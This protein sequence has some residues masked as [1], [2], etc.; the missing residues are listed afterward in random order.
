MVER[1]FLE[2]LVKKL[3]LAREIGSHNG[4]S[5][6]ALQRD[7]ERQMGQVSKRQNGDVI[8]GKGVTKSGMEV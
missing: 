7:V 4:V 8:S 2:I 5:T 3:S 1:S 6:A